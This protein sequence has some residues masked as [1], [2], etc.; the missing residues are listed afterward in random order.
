MKNQIKNLILFLILAFSSSAS[1][2][3]TLTSDEL[4]SEI[5]SRVTPEI[6]TQLKEYSS[7]IKINI[8]G[9]PSQTI[10]TNET[11][12]P[13]IEIISQNNGFSQN[14]YKRILIKDSANRTIKTFAINVQTL[15]YAP[16]LVANEFIPF[17]QTINHFISIPD[18]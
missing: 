5:T 14:S 11:N 18:R 6:K 4:K 10:S 15:V 17:N 2:C 13:K 3:Y 7:D 9:I 1:F 8:I 12:K 16:V